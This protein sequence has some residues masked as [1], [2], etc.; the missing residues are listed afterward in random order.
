MLVCRCYLTSANQALGIFHFLHVASK[1]LTRLLL[2]SLPWN[3][4]VSVACDVGPYEDWGHR[5]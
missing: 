3:L 5:F 4:P 1:T 2:T